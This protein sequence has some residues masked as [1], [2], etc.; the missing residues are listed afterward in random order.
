MFTAFLPDHARDLGLGG[1][2][3]LFA[4]YS[5]VCLLLRF[6]GARSLERLGAHRAVPIAF[7]ALAAALTSLA[8][9]PAVWALWVA[10]IPDRRRPPRS[11]TPR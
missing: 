1:S 7:V 2:G 6:A 9:F 5:G 3:A 10:A 11:S 8:L 4:A